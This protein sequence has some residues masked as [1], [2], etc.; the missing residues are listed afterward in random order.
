[1]IRLHMLYHQI[2]RAAGTN[3]V[4]D[5]IQPFVCEMGVN[6]VKYSY[7]FIHNYV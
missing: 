2:I 3:S 4:F 6:S 1:M 7:F 5:V